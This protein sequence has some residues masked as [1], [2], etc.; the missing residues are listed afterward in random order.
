MRTP[1]A[2]S[3]DETPTLRRRFASM[4]YESLLLLGVLS[5]SFMLPH[6][7][8]G[9][10][11]DLALPGWVLW[12]HVFIVLGAYFAWYWL[13]GG[14]TLA[15]Q[16]WKIRLSTPSGSEPSMRQLALR[17]LLAWPSVICLGA[18]LFWAFFDRD[19]QFLHD[20][21]AGTCLLLKRR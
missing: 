15:M 21:L 13:H 1:A 18:G 12:A 10:A 16:T 2:D 14:Q 3:G 17:Y 8:L 6:L 20:R 4:A 5:V 11:F 7:A 19:R 9:M